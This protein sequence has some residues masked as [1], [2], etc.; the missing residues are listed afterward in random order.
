MSKPDARPVDAPRAE[1][2]QPTPVRV[3]RFVSPQD[4]PGINVT[5]TLTASHVHVLEHLP[6]MRAFRITYRPQEGA[7]RAAYVPEHRV[8]FWEE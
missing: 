5:S 8:S 1:G 4:G 2:R 3:I 7:P 6:W